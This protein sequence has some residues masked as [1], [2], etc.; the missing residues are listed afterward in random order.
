MQSSIRSWACWRTHRDALGQVPALFAV[1]LPA[2]CDHRRVDVHDAGPGHDG[3]TDLGLC[4]LLRD[5]GGHTA[6]NIP[7]TSLMGVISANPIERTTVS[8]FKFVFAFTA[9][10]VVK[11][12]LPHMTGSSGPPTPRVAGQSPSCSSA[13]SRWFSSSSRFLGPRNGCGRRPPE[14]LGWAR[15]GRPLHQWSLADPSRRHGYFHPVRRHAFD[16]HG[17][18]PQILR[19]HKTLTL[20]WSSV[21]RT[22]TYQDITSVFLPIGGTADRSSARRW[23]GGLPAG[24]GRNPR[25]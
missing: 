24:S 2:L 8:S 5:D 1:V 9:G 22:Y 21:A 13:R 17:A 7:Y 20:P 23:S 10:L 14:D 15:P 12:S 19:R 11:F 6:I 25:F 16:D 18:L 4:D 3:E